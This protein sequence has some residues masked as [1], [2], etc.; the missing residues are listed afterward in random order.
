MVIEAEGCVAK[1]FPNFWEVF[2]GLYR[3]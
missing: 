2:Q 1:S 3:Q